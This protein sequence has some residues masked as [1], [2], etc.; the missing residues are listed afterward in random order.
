LCAQRLYTHHVCIRITVT[1]IETSWR[2]SKCSLHAPAR[3]ASIPIVVCVVEVVR[4]YHTS[5]IPALPLRRR[6]CAPTPCVLVWVWL[7]ATCV[8]LLS[9][10]TFVNLL[11]TSTF[12]LVIRLDVPSVASTHTHTPSVASRRTHT[13]TRLLSNLL[14]GYMCLL[15]TLCPRPRLASA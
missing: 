8:N 2:R 11:S 12:Q 3:Y 5:S 15:A 13:P 10:S 14:Y 6:C 1:S 9:T 7:V 4:M